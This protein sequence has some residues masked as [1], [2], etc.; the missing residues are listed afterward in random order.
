[1]KTSSATAGGQR[2]SPRGVWDGVS[3]AE[4]PA[5]ASG[6]AITPQSSHNVLTAAHADGVNQ[7]RHELAATV[8]LALATVATAWSAYQSRTWTGEQSQGY[9]HATAARIAVNRESAL[10][11]RQVQ[12]DVATFIQWINA[13][14]EHRPALA[15]FYRSRFRDEFKPAFAAWLATKPFTNPSA[16]ETPFAMPQYRLT[17]STRADNLESTAA[18]ESLQAKDANQRAD[19]YMLAVVL[20]ASSLFFA[21]ISTKLQTSSLRTTLLVLGWVIFLGTAIWLATFPVRLTT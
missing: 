16:P 19:N 11:N 10:A 7:S 18:A 3:A 14:E 17:A 5:G 9:S 8:L 2:D 15:A 4:T 6:R 20:F 1:M 21:G 12:I 13:H